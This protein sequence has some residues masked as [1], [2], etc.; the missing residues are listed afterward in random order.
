MQQKM[1][2]RNGSTLGLAH[3]SRD[4][5]DRVEE[6]VSGV[7]YQLPPR[8]RAETAE[9]FVVDVKTALDE[10]N[11]SEF[12][13][14]KDRYKQF[15]M[16]MVHK[17][18]PADLEQLVRD[19]IGMWT[20][21]QK[22]NLTFFADILASLADQVH[23]VQSAALKLKR[24]HGHGHV[25]DTQSGRS[26]EPPEKLQK[27]PLSHD[28]LKKREKL[29]N[30]KNKGMKG[31]W[32]NPCLNNDCDGIHP[33]RK[34]L[35]TPKE[36][37]NELLKKLLANKKQSD[38]NTNLASVRS[39]SYTYPNE[40]DGWYSILVND[41]EEV[42]LRDSGADFSTISRT[43]FEKIK[44]QRPSTPFERIEKPMIPELALNR[45]NW[46]SG[47]TAS[48][49]NQLAPTIV[50]PNTGL[51]V[52]VRDKELLMADG[53]MAKVLLGRQFLK[54]IGLDL[55]KHLQKVG[56]GING[57]SEKELRVK[58]ARLFSTAF[59]GLSYQEAEDDPIEPPECLQAGFGVDSNDSIDQ[60]M[61]KAVEET[62]SNIISSKGDVRL[63]TLLESN[64]DGFR[65]KLGPDQPAKVRPLSVKL[66]PNALPFR[67]AQRRYGPKQR[68]FI[69]HTVQQLEK[70]GAVYKNPNARWASLA[71]AL[72]KPGTDKLRFTV[73][74]RGT[75]AR[76]LPLQSSMPH[77]ESMLQDCSE[78]KCFANIYI[79]HGYLQI[80]LDTASQEIMAIQI[81]DGVYAPTRTLQGGPD[82][83]NHFQSDTSEHFAERVEV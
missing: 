23:N 63:K 67:F 78:S 74:L 60:A 75:T 82:P 73:D 70:I 77:L 36:K 72:R 59:K 13:T 10:H 57:M 80:P 69:R 20:A 41:V 71:L 11:A 33:I 65:I 34:C 45:D 28:R 61:R 3:T 15:V 64:R 31:E 8:N 24:K 30:S 14:E 54:A 38:K 18:E 12:I 17:L 27:R 40:N 53:D 2:S 83:G 29:D 32:N 76:T 4:L 52:R 79:T 16:K 6:A 66:R 5:N 35:L 43:V 39:V 47:S 9:Q 44:K 25:R 62:R 1:R 46:A 42:A 22:R 55:G 58:I 49:K 21:E 26:Q 19:E 7:K 50:L 56:T 81:L 51:P 48:G 37:L 68:V